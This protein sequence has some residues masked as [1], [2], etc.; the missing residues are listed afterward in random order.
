[1]RKQGQLESLRDKGFQLSYF[2]EI[3][4]RKGNPYDIDEVSTEDTCHLFH[5]SGSRHEDF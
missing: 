4:L 1:M 3:V 2:Y 5:V